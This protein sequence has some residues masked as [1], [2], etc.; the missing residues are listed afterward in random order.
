MKD[1]AE[2]GEG[3]TSTHTLA[4]TLSSRLQAVCGWAEPRCSE[5][6]KKYVTVCEVWLVVGRQVGRW[7]KGG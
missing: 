3:H 7:A 5:P 6:R 1:N 4:H 2:L